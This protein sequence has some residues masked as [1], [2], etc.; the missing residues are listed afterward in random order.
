MSVE[1]FI[2]NHIVRGNL[3]F[4]GELPASE[5]PWKLYD[6]KGDATFYVNEDHP[7][8]AIN[9]EDKLVP[10]EPPSKE[11]GKNDI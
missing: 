7:V 1:P 2:K 11:N 3:K 5:K 4:L 9:K 6:Y 8:M 10:I